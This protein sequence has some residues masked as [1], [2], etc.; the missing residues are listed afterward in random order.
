MMSQ[1]VN[2]YTETMA[3]VYAEQGH[4]DK[5]VEIYRHLL[6]L[7]PERL[8]YADALAEAENRVAVAEDTGQPSDKLVSLFREWIDLLFKYEKQQKLKQLRKRRRR[9]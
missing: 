5:V 3:R 1:D 8:E 9:P 4:W 2:I 7:E 6:T